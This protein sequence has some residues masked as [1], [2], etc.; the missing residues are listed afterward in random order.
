MQRPALRGQAVVVAEPAPAGG[1]RVRC[2]SR[3]ALRLGVRLGMPLAEVMALSG[4]GDPTV[5]W[6]MEPHTPE[7]DRAM[8]ET[9]AVECETESPWVSLAYEPDPDSLLLDLSGCG[10]LHPN[11]GRLARGL[12]RQ[13]TDQGWVVRVVV[14][15]TPAA[16][17]A[18]ARFETPGSSSR[19][20]DVRIVPATGLL[21]ALRDLPLAA[22]R[23]TPA[24]L[25]QFQELGLETVGQL[26]ALNRASL[27]ARF[28]P[29]P[30]RRLD[31]LLGRWGEP[32]PP[33]RPT[34][35][36]HVEQD[37]E[38]PLTHPA[39]LRHML[40]WTVGQAIERL[41]SPTCGVLRLALRLRC[42]GGPAYEHEVPLYRPTRSVKHLVELIELELERRDPGRP[43]LALR[44]EVLETQPLERRQVD[45]F[46][47]RAERATAAWHR[48]VDRL[49]GRL[50]RAG[51]AR[52]V[53]VA[54]AQP[55]CAARMVAWVDRATVA[56]TADEPHR[57]T[58]AFRPMCLI[59]PPRPLLV[60]GP[61]DS[62]P[63]ARFGYEG[64]IYETHRWWG[65]ERIETGWWRGAAARRDYFRL[66]THDARR[67]WVFRC[68]DQNRW[69]LHG[70]FD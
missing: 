57:A 46:N 68:L 26:L 56:A 40:E 15:E 34:A 51:V 13:L 24:M 67:L 70:W 58:A 36:A 21:E 18:I 54:D 9:L 33:Q 19:P 27:P 52:A 10:R 29:E 30:G 69:Y 53:L 2:G 11:L 63:P 1:G 62:R 25:R 16:A 7:A 41:G 38:H 28:G 65:P 60:M 50:G 49:T 35:S 37:C 42:E 3:Q 47:H 39:A 22:L 23:L 6:H 64:T 17:W 59:A 32:P 4:G 8:L 45:L 5:T 55:E 66:E 31:E 61:S 12:H 14:A 48:L 44:V 43:I 20:R